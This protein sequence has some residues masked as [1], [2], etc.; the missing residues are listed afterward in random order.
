MKVI[1]KF[2]QH[3]YLIS[4]L[5]V[6]LQSSAQL[7]ELGPVSNYC[8]ECWKKRSLDVPE[9]Y[10]ADIDQPYTFGHCDLI[11]QVARRRGFAPDIS[12]REDVEND[13]RLHLMEK[14]AAIEKGVRDEAME[15]GIN[16]G[17][18]DII[19]NYVRKTLQ[20]LLKDKQQKSSE[21]IVV[22]NTVKSLSPE[23][24]VKTNR[25]QES[26][27]RAGHQLTDLTGGDSASAHDDFSLDEKDALFVG[28]PSNGQKRSPKKTEARYLFDTLMAEASSQITTLTGGRK[29]G[30]DV[31]LDLQKALSKL[32][33][34]ESAVFSLL[35]LEDGDLLARP[36]TYNDVQKESGLSLQNVRTL[37]ARA[38]Q[39]LKPALG[40]SFFRRRK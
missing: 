39:K 32:L 29:D 38:I 37:E 6:K 23:G 24:L 3:N 11:S 17:D 8:S 40:P 31:R 21:G 15:Q 1:L 19:R 9:P 26:Q 7:A 36:R 28:G 4:P 18:P 30:F 5:D 13:L 22:R 16:P 35:W 12:A 2:C 20:N 27:E 25:R 34:E 10:K 33:A 14:R